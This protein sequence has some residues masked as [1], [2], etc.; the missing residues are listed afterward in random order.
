MHGQSAGPSYTQ[1]RDEEGLGGK[2]EGWRGVTGGQEERRN[3]DLW[4]N[5]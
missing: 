5:L 4:F 1:Q 3:K 2:K